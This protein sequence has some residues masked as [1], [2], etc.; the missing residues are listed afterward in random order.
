MSFM[1]I[2]LL[3]EPNGV[4]LMMIPVWDFEY[5]IIIFVYSNAGQLLSILHVC[6][7]LHNIQ[8][9]LT[10]ERFGIHTYRID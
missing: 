10:L 7:H 8:W 2:H 1:N 3:L 9:Y 6:R 4:K 5:A